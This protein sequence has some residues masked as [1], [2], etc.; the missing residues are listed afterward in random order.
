M[1]PIAL[2]LGF[3]PAKLNWSAVATVKP[4]RG[5]GKRGKDKQP[6]G[7]PNKWGLAKGLNSRSH[8]EYVRQWRAKR[9]AKTRDHL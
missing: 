9:K 1:T 4:K 7:R 8:A 3:D 2:S 5:T 6:H